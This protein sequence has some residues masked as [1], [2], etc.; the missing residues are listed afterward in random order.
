ME[1]PADK[2]TWPLMYKSLGND[3]NA[4]YDNIK[5]SNKIITQFLIEKGIDEKEIRH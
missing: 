2:V 3:L 1:V 4:L 5:N